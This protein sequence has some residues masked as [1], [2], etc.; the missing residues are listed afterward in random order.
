MSKIKL[1]ATN[2]LA[3]LF[4]CVLLAVHTHTH[5][6]AIVLGVQQYSLQKRV[7]WAEQRFSKDRVA[8][9]GKE[10]GPRCTVNQG[11]HASKTV[12]MTMFP[13]HTAVQP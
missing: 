4:S 2:S 11:Y 12:A 6:Q 9:G 8:E 10:L 3:L 7:K 1:S 13:L 5:S